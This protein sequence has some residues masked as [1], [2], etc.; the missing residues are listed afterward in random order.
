MWKANPENIDIGHD[1]GEALNNLGN[2][3][4]DAGQ[5]AEAEQAFRRS[6]EIR[7]ALWKANPE[8][9]AIGDGLGMALNNLGNLL[10]DA[11][12]V[13]EA[14]QAFRRSVEI[15]EALW[16]ANPENVA[17]G[18]GLGMALNNLGTLL[19]DAGRVAEAEQAYRRSVE[20]RE[21]LW[22]ANPEHIE[23]TVS[24]A[25]SLCSVG[26]WGE[27]DRL[28][29]EVLERVPN[30]PDANQLR[31][32][33]ASQRRGVRRRRRPHGLHRPRHDRPPARPGRP[34]APGLPRDDQATDDDARGGSHWRLGSL[35]GVDLQGPSGRWLG[36]A[37][38]GPEDL[39]G[40]DP[41]Q[42]G[43]R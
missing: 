25:W 29:G 40:L 28:V 39:L 23:I 5:V 22:K 31:D 30:H 32:Y 18:D 35:R 9:V 10:S 2:L 6:V 8:N 7:E 27:A 19:S 15:F 34:V 14:E 3:L 12:Q 42:V 43:S 24:F 4:S 38:S 16:K 13:A 1:L 41:S 17:I 33:I 21:V 20:I 11:G 36:R 26:R 37:S